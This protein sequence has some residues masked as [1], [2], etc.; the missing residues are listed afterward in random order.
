MGWVISSGSV[1]KDYSNYFGE[2]Q[3]FP[4]IGP[5]PT[6]WPFMAGLRTAMAHVGMSFSM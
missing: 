1:W 3:G 2:W 4:G 5:P 6:F